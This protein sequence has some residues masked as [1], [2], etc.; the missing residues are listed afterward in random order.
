MRSFFFHFVDRFMEESFS[1]FRDDVLF[2]SC[3]LRNKLLEPEKSP[4][5]EKVHHFWVSAVSFQ[6]F[7]L[8]WMKNCVLFFDFFVPK[9]VSLQKSIMVFPQTFS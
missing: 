7:K 6:G 4:R 8:I 5:S 9:K 1:K 2:P 3:S